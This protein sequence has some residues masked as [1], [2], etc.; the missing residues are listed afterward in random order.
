MEK[1]NN[2][3]LLISK[4]TL[5]DFENRNNIPKLVQIIHDNGVHYDNIDLNTYDE[6]YWSQK[7]PTYP[8]KVHE[9]LAKCNTEKIHDDY[10]IM[11]KIKQ[12]VNFN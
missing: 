10:K 9:F 2:E 3:N 8:K 5:N 6:T 12:D 11:K 4:N 7:Y 1:K